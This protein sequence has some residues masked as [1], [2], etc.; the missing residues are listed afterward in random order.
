MPVTHKYSFFVNSVQQLVSSPERY[1]CLNDEHIAEINKGNFSLVN[2]GVDGGEGKKPY[3]LQFVAHSNK[4]L[5]AA[6]GNHPTSRK[7]T[8]S[9]NDGY[10]INHA[11]DADGNRSRRTNHHS[12]YSTDIP[13]GYYLNN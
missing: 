6:P 12:G 13:F 10:G 5:A 3:Q 11:D 7:V 1:N 2:R 4:K 9:H 8:P